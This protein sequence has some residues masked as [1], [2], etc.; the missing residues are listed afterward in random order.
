[1]STSHGLEKESEIYLEQ[2][3]DLL[4]AEYGYDCWIANGF[5]KEIYA[6]PP[7]TIVTC[8]HFLNH[9]SFAFS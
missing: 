5:I 8:T 3:L 2:I 4:R 6:V 7:L 1:M 9:V